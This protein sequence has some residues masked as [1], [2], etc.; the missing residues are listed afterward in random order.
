MI[1]LW[2]ERRV[3]PF[4]SRNGHWVYC[5][6]HFVWYNAR[7]AEPRHLARQLCSSLSLSLSD[8]SQDIIVLIWSSGA[9]GMAHRTSLCVRR[10]LRARSPLFQ[11]PLLAFFYWATRAA[12][13]ICRRHQLKERFASGAT[14]Y[15]IWRRVYSRKLLL[16]IVGSPAPAQ[17]TFLIQELCSAI[18]KHIINIKSLDNVQY[19]CTNIWWN[20]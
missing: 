16:W 18:L 11:L 3:E 13:I 6:V 7:A 15:R 2:I 8:I 20:Y 9:D 14:H 19:Y 5:T 4:Y 1:K 12:N 10:V 17:S